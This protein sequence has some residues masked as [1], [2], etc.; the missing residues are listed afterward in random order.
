MNNV[1]RWGMAL[2][3]LAGLARVVPVSAVR[4]QLAEADRFW[5]LGAAV[6]A[7]LLHVLQ[8]LRLWWVARACG[9]AWT[10]GAA[11]RLHFASLFYAL[12]VPGGNLTGL[13][14]RSRQL[15]RLDQDYGSAALVLVL[16]RV[17]STTTLALTGLL[18]LAAA[19]TV[20]RP[21]LAVVFTMVFV[22]GWTLILLARRGVHPEDGPWRRRLPLLR[23]LTGPVN[24]LAQV[25]GQV[26]WRWAAWALALHG[27]GIVLFLMV[28]RSA[29]LVLGFGET[30]S[31]RASMLVAA[32]P[33]ITAGGLGLREG[34]ATLLLGQGP[35]TPD[36]ALAF[37]LL[38]FA[39]TVLLPA[40][41]GGL[42]ELYANLRPS[43]P[44]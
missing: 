19:P 18:S 15:G 32:L 4:V 21:V 33:P 2:L 31:A 30:A 42:W 39:S 34:T 24:R 7:L 40:L 16:D 38:V 36:Q 11:L 29:N 37:S 35:A 12:V 43:S 22:A 1:L 17:L 13:L 10:R 26:W 14:V 28:A 25:S 44:G 41:L 5:F 27:I 8:G 20:A 6:L 9:W 3:L 23:Y